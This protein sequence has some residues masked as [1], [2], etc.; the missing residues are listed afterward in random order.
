[1]ERK[2]HCRGLLMDGKLDEAQFAVLES[3]VSE[4][5]RDLR[6]SALDDRFD[7]LPYGL[8]KSLRDMLA[9][10]R[11][12]AWERKHVVRALDEDDVLTKAQKK[13]VRDLVD[14]WF[15]RDAGTSA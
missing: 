12:S 8:V 4:L 6:V 2:A 10:G 3:R 14:G 13:K 11:V 9:D 7:F 5:A 1:M 15:R